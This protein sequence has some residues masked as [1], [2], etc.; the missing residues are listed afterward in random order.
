MESTKRI[1]LLS[2]VDTTENEMGSHTTIRWGSLT[3][4]TRLSDVDRIMEGL[5]A[6]LLYEI[7]CIKGDYYFAIRVLITPD[8]STDVSI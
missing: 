6:N 2:H 1:L 3:F 4:E 7:T 8:Y 5:I